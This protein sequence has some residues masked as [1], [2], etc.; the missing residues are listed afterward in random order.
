[1]YVGADVGLGIGVL[2]VSWSGED[3]EQLT[4]DFSRFC[5]KGGHVFHLAFAWIYFV[6]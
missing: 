3:K 5:G 4:M 1:M 6:A 2:D